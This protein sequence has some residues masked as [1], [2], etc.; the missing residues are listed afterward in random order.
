[1]YAP[2]HAAGT[3]RVWVMTRR[4]ADVNGLGWSPE[5]ARTCLDA[6]AGRFRFRVETQNVFEAAANADHRRKDSSAH[7][8]RLAAVTLP[9]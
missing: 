1:M 6:F 5:F 2:Q 7:D 3:R 9:Q 8:A 4:L